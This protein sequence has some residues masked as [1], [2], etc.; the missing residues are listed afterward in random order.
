MSLILTEKMNL[1][2]RNNQGGYLMRIKMFISYSSRDEEFVKEIELLIARKFR[3][4]I[5]P[6]KF[7]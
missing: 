1:D 7:F 2:K 3:D 6:V 5:E 4:K